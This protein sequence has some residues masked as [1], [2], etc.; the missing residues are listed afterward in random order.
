MKGVA[1]AVPPPTLFRLYRA[2]VNYAIAAHLSLRACSD[3]E[4]AYVIDLLPERNLPCVDHDEFALFAAD[5]ATQ[6]V[7]CTASPSEEA[8]PSMLQLGTT[9][10]EGLDV[11]PLGVS[12]PSL[13]NIDAVHSA[14]DLDDGDLP[15]DDN[16]RKM[17]DSDATARPRQADVRV[18][19]QPRGVSTSYWS[20]LHAH[21]SRTWRR[22]VA[23]VWRYRSIW[24]HSKEHMEQHLADCHWRRYIRIRTG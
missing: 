3:L 19:P 2:I 8:L 17:G 1:A 10:T 5:V 12:S 21:G 4:E 23:L 14:G 22:K 9:L 18:R 16:D 7:N 15:L 13:S 6:A 24:H 11:S 20:Q